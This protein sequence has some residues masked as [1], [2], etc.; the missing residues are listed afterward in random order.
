MNTTL[1]NVTFRHPKTLRFDSDIKF[2]MNQEYPLI[3]RRCLDS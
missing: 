3:M 1:I 2:V